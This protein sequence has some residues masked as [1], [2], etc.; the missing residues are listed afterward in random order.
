MSS[1]QEIITESDGIS[2]GAQISRIITS[3]VTT[4]NSYQTA[5]LYETS[6]NHAYNI[7]T[8]IT[9]IVE[10]GS[11]TGIFNNTTKCKNIS[12]VLTI[13]P[14]ISRVSSLDDLLSNPP[15]GDEA[16]IRVN[17]DGTTIDIQVR[18]IANA[19]VNWAIGATIVEQGF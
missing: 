9:C 14:N 19:T 8:E 1:S 17:N 7:V 10:G 6:T 3:I 15:S 16:D 4:D 12:N 2:N 13:T 11:D 18:G 5:Y